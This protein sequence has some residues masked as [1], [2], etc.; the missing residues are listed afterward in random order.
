MFEYDKIINEQKN[1]NIVEKVTDYEVGATHYLP[2]RPVIRE[3]KETSKTRIVFD[4]SCKSRVEGPSLNIL[5]FGPSLTTLLT[6]SLLRSRS[7][8]Y[9]EVADIEKGFHKIGLN[10][11]HRDLVRFLWF[12]DI[13]NL[14]FERFEKNSLID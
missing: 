5:D 14:D 7:F 4:A 12:K 6:D 11:N 3:D 1:F 2:H 9:V 8:N 13:E 10:P